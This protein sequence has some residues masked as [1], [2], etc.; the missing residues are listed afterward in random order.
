LLLFVLTAA[1]VCTG[2]TPAEAK[3]IVA[4][5]S[6]VGIDLGQVPYSVRS[7]KVVDPFDF[8]KWVKDKRHQAETDITGL[9]KPKTDPLKRFTYATAVGEALGIIEKEEFLPHT[10]APVRLLVEF[11]SVENCSQGQVD[12]RYRVYSTQFLSALTG[13]LEE[14]VTERKTPDEAAGLPKTASSSPFHF[15]PVAGYDSIDK[16]SGGGRLEVIPKHTGTFPFRSFSIQGQGSSQSRMLSAALSGSTDSVGWLAHSE[17]SLDY[18]NYSLPTGSGKLQ[19]GQLSAQFSGTTQ[20]FGNG[21]F[22]ARFGGLLEGGNRQSALQNVHLA[23]RTVASEHF[24]ALKLYAGLNSRLSHNVFSASYGLELGSVGGGARVDWRKHILDFKHEFWYPLGDH[25]ILSLESQFTA[26]VIQVPGKI[27]LAMRFFGGNNEQQFISGDSWRIRANPVIR[28]IPGNSFFRTSEGDGG[29]RFF[30]YNL[31]A[32]YPLWR[33]PLVPQEITKDK[34]FND[35]LNGQLTNAT[36]NEQLYF[37]TKDP[38]YIALVGEVPGVRTTLAR[39]KQ[40]VTTSQTGHPGQF[41]KEFK[42]CLGRIDRADSR[43]KSAVQAKEPAK[44]G[45]VAT[46]LSTDPD[47]DQLSKAIKSCGNDGLN[48]T[49]Q[50]PAIEIVIEA[51]GNPTIDQS[52]E[53]IR[54]RMDDEFRRIDVSGAASK[55]NADMAFTRRTLNTLFKEVNIYSVSPVFVFDVAKIGP[56]NLGLGGVRYGPGVGLRLELA[57]VANFTT[58]Y[59]WNVR[60]HP[61]EGQGT[62]FFSIGLRE[63]FR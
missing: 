3:K 27:P 25:R 47:E 59:A 2:Q 12:L 51:K 58:G 62:V 55:A 29:N 41:P 30:S 35:L 16:L 28:A 48:K 18:V 1:N 7:V 13:S 33:E 46:L 63:L 21:N 26:G 39:L 8:L 22:T 34:T 17:W 9:L 11:V 54:N 56:E 10:E 5:K 61:G 20:P 49:L 23:P 24:G 32:A 43:A 4:E 19:G 50:E 6:C 31:T 52:L 40:A 60:H 14:R 15:T 38:A 45:F 57:S 44:Y 37:T 36:S 53:G 42:A